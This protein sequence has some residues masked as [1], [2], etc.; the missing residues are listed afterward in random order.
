[1]FAPEATVRG[2]CAGTLV[3]SLDTMEYV[4][5]SPVPVIKLSKLKFNATSLQTVTV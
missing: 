5:V 2:L 3:L 1:M 4:K